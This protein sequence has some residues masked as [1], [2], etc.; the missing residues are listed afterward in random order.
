MLHEDYCEHS[1]SHKAFSNQVAGIPKV[2]W[3]A[4]V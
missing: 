3:T 2:M 4:A 1:S